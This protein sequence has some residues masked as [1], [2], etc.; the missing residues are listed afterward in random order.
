MI[1]RFVEDALELARATEGDLNARS[2][3]RAVIHDS[4]TVLAMTRARETARR[5][6]VL[7]VNRFLRIAQTA[8]YGI[9]IGKDVKVGRGIFFAHPL[10]IV[11]GGDAR[12]GDRLRFLCG[13][14]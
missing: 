5:W 10:G 7:G 4:Y 8:V 14:I 2:I 12:I 9:E 13:H 1:G 11:I 6:H 3:Y